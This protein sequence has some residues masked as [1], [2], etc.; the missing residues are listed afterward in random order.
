MEEPRT[1]Q[2][3][4][5]RSGEVFVLADHTKINEV[6]NF[7]VCGYESI[8]HIITNPTDCMTENQAACLDK[9]RNKGVEIIFADE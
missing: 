5:R 9:F 4:I 6:S 3:L 8:S 1:K 7:Q 2:S